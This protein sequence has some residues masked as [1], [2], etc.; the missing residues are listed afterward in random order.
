[1]VYHLYPRS[2]A[3]SD[4]DGIGDLPGI[5]ARLGHLAELGVGAVWLSPV[6]RSP[7]R[8]FGYDISDHTDVDPV[9]GDLADFDR[10]LARA[11]GLG[12][13]VILDFVPNHTSD[14][15]PWFRQSRTARSSARRDW[16]HWRD[17]ASDG[18]PPNNWLSTFG[19]P[20]WSFDDGTGQYYLHSFLPSMPDLN[21]RE[22]AVAE[23]MLDV[24]RFWLDRGV[25]GFR[26]DCAPQ[27]GKD[28]LLRDNPAAPAGS[29][30]MHRP[31]GDYDS[32]V[33][34]HDQGHPDAHAAYRRLRR[35]LQEYPGPERV[36]LGEI[37]DNDL[38]VWASYYGTA[39]DELHLPMA[40]E[41]LAC[42]WTPDGVRRAVEATTSAIP[43]GGRACW[44]LGNHDERR[45]AGR[46]GPR[47]ARNAMLVLLTLDGVPVLYNGDELALPDLLLD[48]ADIRDPWGRARPE[49]SRDAAR[50]PLPW[51]EG[52]GAGFTTPDATPWLP[53]ADTPTSVA[54]QS[55]DPGSML[56]LTRRLLTARAAHPALRRGTLCFLDGL[57]PDVLGYLRRD[58]EGDP[59]LVLANLG[60][61]NVRTGLAAQEWRIVVST[62]EGGAGE[63]ARSPHDLRPHEGLLLER[64]DRRG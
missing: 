51:E 8:D 36:A 29:A 61:R 18:G 7:M 38:A 19:G 53:F 45:V 1:M 39:L 41:L 46:L 59:M 32:Q 52:P 13:K 27:I 26:V 34:L 16:Y 9:F 35:L 31:L 2:F 43:D 17:P 28:P 48:P 21:W 30:A 5:T 23:A 60:E 40:F 50:A 6:Y 15:H 44:V 56:T 54:A 49:L 20:A 14:A 47:Q 55:A 57:P 37:H 33:H 63:T 12:L 10:M 62:A 22:P 11:H 64:R 24:A 25:D 3:D 4:G 58:A 42:P